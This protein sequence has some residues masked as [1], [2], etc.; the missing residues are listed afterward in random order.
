MNDMTASEESTYHNM[1]FADFGKT[2]LVIID[3]RKGSD[4]FRTP[5]KKSMM[6]VEPVL[7]IDKELRIVTFMERSFILD[8]AP[9]NINDNIF[10]GDVSLLP[11]FPLQ[12]SLGTLKSP[13]EMIP[14]HRLLKD[15]LQ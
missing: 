10:V 1:N 13:D 2:C 7:I 14:W 15:H 6:E 11:M 5:L 3:P 4:R 8:M 12:L 9:Q